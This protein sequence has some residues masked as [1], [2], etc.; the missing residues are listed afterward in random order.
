MTFSTNRVYTAEQQALLRLATK[1][2]NR[3]IR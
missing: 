3:H 2:E 1:L